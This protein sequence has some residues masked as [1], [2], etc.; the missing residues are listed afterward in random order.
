MVKKLSAEHMV[1]D[2]F[3]NLAQ[4]EQDVAAFKPQQRQQPRPQNYNWGGGNNR[5]HGQNYRGNSN[6]RQNF[7]QDSSQPR[8]NFSRNGKYCVYCKMMNHAQEECR[9]RI[10]D[11]QPCVNNK[12]QMYWPKINNTTESPNTVQQNSNPIVESIFEPM[13]F[14]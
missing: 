6:N 12:R 2:E 11:K 7:N 5:S 1:M 9:K 10:N 14:H 8:N 3:E 4:Q 13:V